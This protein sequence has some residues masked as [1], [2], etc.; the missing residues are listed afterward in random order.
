MLSVRNIFVAF[1]CLLNSRM[2]IIVDIMLTQI[3]K[4]MIAGGKLTTFRRMAERAV[5]MACD[6]LQQQG[7]QLP[8]PKGVSEELLL[9]GGETGDDVSDYAERL[10]QRWPE[11]DADVVDHLVACYGSNAERLVGVMSADPI[12][13]TR[14]APK[15]AITRAEVEYAVRDE[16]A[17]TLEDFLERRSRLLLWDPDNGLA[18]AEGVART[19][20]GMLDWDD[21]RIE[22]EVMRY[23]T[24]AQRLKHF[25]AD[26][27]ESELRQVAHG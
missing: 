21:T 14:Y 24:H 23:R 27:A 3:M 18:V 12:L 5:D 1:L 17:M 4:P 2:T 6:Q 7:Q 26:E 15:L 22:A 13:G 10:K 25:E 20:G 9:S 11:I 19:M 16:M 8:A